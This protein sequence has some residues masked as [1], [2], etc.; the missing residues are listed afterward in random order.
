MVSSSWNTSHVQ[1]SQKLHIC[2]EPLP[3]LA[4]LFSDNPLHS[5][6]R[7]SRSHAPFNYEYSRTR[8]TPH[9]HVS[10]CTVVVETVWRIKQKLLRVRCEVKYNS[11]LNGARSLSWYTLW[12]RMNPVH[13]LRHHISFRYVLILSSNL[14]LGFSSGL[15]LL[16]FPI[17]SL[18]AV[19]ISPTRVCSYETEVLQIM[20]LFVKICLSCCHFPATPCCTFCFDSV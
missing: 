10:V 17:R 1:C 8:D 14:C 18:Y 15:F 2:P 19:R 4:P 5:S 13:I 16:G 9:L 11:S 20:K 3:A 7:L 12:T 6:T